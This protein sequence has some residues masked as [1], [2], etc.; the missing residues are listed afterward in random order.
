VDILIIEMW[1]KILSLKVAEQVQLQQIEEDARAAEAELLKKGNYP[2]DYP[3]TFFGGK[4]S[5]S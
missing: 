1:G 3:R 5:L 4:F 2:F